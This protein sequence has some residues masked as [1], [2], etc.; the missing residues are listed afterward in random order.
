MLYLLFAGLVVGII[1]I[2]INAIVIF[3]SAY[4]F[5]IVL[6]T[7]ISLSVAFFFK[8]KSL[9]IKESEIKE[10]KPKKTISATDKAEIRN[11]FDKK[12]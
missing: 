12:D 5:Q 2:I 6:I 7:L 9:F 3:G 8:F 10:E 1:T 4:A 11:S